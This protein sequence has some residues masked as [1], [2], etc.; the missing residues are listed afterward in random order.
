M[1]S[2]LP[3]GKRVSR[4]SGT[5]ANIRGANGEERRENMLRLIIPLPSTIPIRPRSRKRKRP[6]P[7]HHD[8]TTGWRKGVGPFALQNFRR[9][10]RA[11][12]CGSVLNCGQILANCVA[13]I[14]HCLFFR[15]PLR[16]APRQRRAFSN[17]YAVLVRFNCDAKFHVT[18]VANRRSGSQR[19]HLRSS[20]ST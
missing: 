20:Y 19:E 4:S 18:S 3:G 5:I 1:N 6:Q 14:F 12:L 16:P 17:E 9:S 11:P 7:K 13:N 8:A 15:C 10:L 2:S